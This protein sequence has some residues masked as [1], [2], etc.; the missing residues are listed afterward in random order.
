M[1]NAEVVEG[2]ANAEV[3]EEVAQ[4]AQARNR[5]NAE[6]VEEVAQ[7]AQAIHHFCSQHENQDNISDEFRQ[8]D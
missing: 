6:V 7:A 3:V 4:T 5:E 8:L 1:S 2:E